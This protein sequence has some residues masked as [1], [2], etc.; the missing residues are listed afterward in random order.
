M[1]L[2][3]APVFVAAD[4]VVATPERAIKAVIDHETFDTWGNYSFSDFGNADVKKLYGIFWDSDLVRV[5]NSEEEANQVIEKLS[6]AESTLVG[7]AYGET[8]SIVD[9]FTK[10]D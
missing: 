7:M 4:R 1:T 3:V 6:Q 8:V 10:I 5:C 2:I 9:C